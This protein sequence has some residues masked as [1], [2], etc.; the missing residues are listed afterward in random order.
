MSVL[1]HHQAIVRKECIRTVVD[2]SLICS[3]YFLLV[4]GRATD[5]DIGKEKN[6]KDLKKPLWK[7]RRLGEPKRD[8]IYLPINF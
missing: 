7:R 5:E 8:S 4:V 1:L 3:H 6:N 2:K